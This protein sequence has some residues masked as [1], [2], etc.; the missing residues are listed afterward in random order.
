MSTESR[1]MEWENA[2]D[3][4]TKDELYFVME[5]PEGFHSGFL[6]M[7]KTKME[8][9]STMPEHEAMKMV[10]KRI[11]EGMGC[12]CSIDE[13]GDLNFDYQGMA[14]NITFTE[15]SHWISICDYNWKTVKLDDID[16][17][18]RLKRAIN[19]ANQDSVVNTVYEII[20]EEQ[21]M[22]IYC[23]RCIL[24]RPMITNFKKHL[25]IILH[26]FFH[27]HNLL[28][29]ELVLLQERDR[30]NQPE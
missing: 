23:T 5:H 14:F 22:Y 24:Y 17:V 18:V 16:E 30:Q 10:I 26:N 9:L 3:Q 15:K 20:E 8:E 25:E 19:K 13:D 27:A 21:E 2:I 6:K 7:A 28:N 4:M 1:K 12:P 11:L 29:A